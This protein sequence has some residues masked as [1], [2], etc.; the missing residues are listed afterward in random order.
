MDTID[1]AHIRRIADL[2]GILTA[3][4]GQADRNDRFCHAHHGDRDPALQFY[5]D[6]NTYHC[7]S[8]ESGGD[9]FDYM[10]ETRNMTALEVRDL[11]DPGAA[12]RP[13][14]LRPAVSADPR[15]RIERP[16]AHLDACWQDAV[17]EFVADSR[18]CLWLPEGRPALDYLHGRG[19][20]DTTLRFFGIGFNPRGRSLGSFDVLATYPSG[21]DLYAVRGIVI[22]LIARGGWFD[23]EHGTRFNYQGAVIRRQ[24]NDPRDPLPLQSNGK[25]AQRYGSLKGTSRHELFPF[26]DIDPSEFPT[27]AIVTEGEI[28]AMTVWQEARHL[29]IPATLGGAAARPSEHALAQLRRCT[30]LLIATDNFDRRGIEAYEKWSDRF[31][32]MIVKRGRLPFGKDVND[33]HAGG[34]NVAEWVAERF[35]RF[36]LMS[37]PGDAFEGDLPD[38][39]PRLIPWSP[40]P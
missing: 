8:C 3:D 20:A 14:A 11:V 19:L 27:P 32:G 22:P 26:P 29:A 9:F 13:V 40:T 39:L 36:D 12:A 37:K 18:D 24:A 6:T 33:Y 4:C 1:F 35:R 16:A 2:R 10:K 31:A 15:P 25:A 21:R 5:A 30:H 34:G 17:A 7:W 38:T 23:P 28:D